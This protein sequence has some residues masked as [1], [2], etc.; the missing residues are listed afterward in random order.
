MMARREAYLKV[1]SF[2][3]AFR[4]CEE[5]DLAIRAAQ[6]GAHFIAVDQPLVTQYK[7]QSPDKSGMKPLHYALMLRDKHREYLARKG[8]YHASRMFARSNFWS[9]KKDKLKSR[10]YRALGYAVA[11]QLIPG[12]LKRRSAKG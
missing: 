5:L 8:L 2:D 9:S 3:A 6:M 7:T 4:R 10:F 12:Y 11:P 1:G